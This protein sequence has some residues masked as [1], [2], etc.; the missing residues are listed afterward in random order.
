MSQTQDDIVKTLVPYCY[1]VEDG[2]WWNV[3]SNAPRV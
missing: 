1:A 3:S 2:G